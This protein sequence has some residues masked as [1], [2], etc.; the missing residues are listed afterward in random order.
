VEGRL[1]R[2]FARGFEAQTRRSGLGRG[3]D[4]STQVGNPVSEKKKEALARLLRVQTLFAA[5]D[6]IRERKEKGKN[7]K[8]GEWVAWAYPHRRRPIY[9]GLP[10]RT[11]T[12]TCSSGGYSS[13]AC[14]ML[15]M[16]TEGVVGP[17]ELATPA[18]CGNL[19]VDKVGAGD[20]LTGAVMVMVIIIVEKKIKRSRREE[21]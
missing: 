15:T 1:A 16:R 11:T 12:G 19:E 17:R 20:S 6:Y 10:T 14:C 7:G 2:R 8:E 18:E 5:K 13:P 9:H 21:G 4:G 3:R